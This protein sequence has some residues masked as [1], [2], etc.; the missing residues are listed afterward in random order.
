M[1]GATLWWGMRN[2]HE[3]AVPHKAVHARTH[4]V[5]VELEQHQALQG[6]QVLAVPRR[7]RPPGRL[8]VDVGQEDGSGEIQVQV[9]GVLPWLERRGERREEQG[10]R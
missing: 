8:A 1:Q 4:V 6:G 2:R 3:T 9:V 10:G 7:P 5:I